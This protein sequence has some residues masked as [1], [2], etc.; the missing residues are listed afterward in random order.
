VEMIFL[1][2]R[3][4]LAFV[5]MIGNEQPIKE[6]FEWNLPDRLHVKE[7][8][9]GNG[10]WWTNINYGIVIRETGWMEINVRKFV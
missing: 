7:K 1:T 3:L 5:Q 2:R 10:I 9:E 8:G 4:L 6:C